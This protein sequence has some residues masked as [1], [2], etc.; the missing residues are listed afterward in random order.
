MRKKREREREREKKVGATGYLPSDHL[1]LAAKKVLLNK[2]ERLQSLL[3]L[4]FC[5][6]R[7]EI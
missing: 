1:V 4:L 2:E 6:L 3:K 5:P 7:S